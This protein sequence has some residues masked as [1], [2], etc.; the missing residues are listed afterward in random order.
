MNGEIIAVGSE[1]LLGQIVNSNA[2]YLSKQLSNIG[3]NVYHHAVVGDNEKRLSEVLAVACNRSDLVIITGGL[4]PTKDDLT[5]ET[6]GKFLHKN[7]VYD[8]GTEM[9]I[10]EYFQQRNREM[11]ENNRKQAL[12]L[13]GSH[14]FPNDHGLACGLAIKGE[15]PQTQFIMLPGPPSELKPMFETYVIPYL[16]SQLGEKA[17]IQSRVLRFFDI[18]ESQLAEKLDDLLESQTNPTIAP[19][20]S[21]GEVTLRLTVKGENEVTNEQLLDETAAKILQRVGDY[22][23][24][25]GENS[26]YHMLVHLL[27]QQGYTLSSAESITGGLFASEIISI[28]GAG[29]VFSGGVISYANDMKEEPLGVKEEILI[30][31]GAVSLTCAKEMAFKIREQGKTDFGISFTG[32]AGPDPLEGKKPGLVYIGISSQLETKGYMIQLAGSRNNIRSRSAKYGAY[33]LLQWI[34]KEIKK[35]DE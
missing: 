26:I 30:E 29:S 9:K 5:K 12:I 20:A 24:G 19:L 2:T 23:Y 28:P 1:L 7:L 34:R 4:G 13:E 21:D 22:F 31:E 27:N 18:G 3:I 16:T 14:V 15:D 35:V 25:T 11:T 6:V 8:E 10:N 33:F 32:V 17:F